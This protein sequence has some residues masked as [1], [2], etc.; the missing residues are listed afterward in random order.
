MRDAERSAARMP[1]DWKAASKQCFVLRAGATLAKMGP[2]ARCT[3]VI[4]RNFAMD[5]N[6]GNFYS[7]IPKNSELFGAQY[8]SIGVIIDT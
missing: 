5:A 3:Q 7:D 8:A 6:N 1:V 4:M 2:R